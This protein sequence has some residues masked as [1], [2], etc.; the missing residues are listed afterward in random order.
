VSD[1]G[2]GAASS[3]KSDTEKAIA[4][5]NKDSVALQVPYTFYAHTHI[6]YVILICYVMQLTFC[7]PFMEAKDVKESDTVRLQFPHA[8]RPCYALW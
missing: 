4:A 8:S 5:E 2:N 1:N 3:P 6:F 7:E